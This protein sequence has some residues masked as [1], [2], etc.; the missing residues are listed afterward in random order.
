MMID[1]H[2]DL[3]VSIQLRMIELER[4]V[5]ELRRERDLRGPPPYGRPMPVSTHP[6][7]SQGQPLPGATS[8]ASYV[9][10][11]GLNGEPEVTRTKFHEATEPP[12]LYRSATLSPAYLKPDEG[13]WDQSYLSK[14]LQ[15]MKDSEILEL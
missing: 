13:I 14:A 5:R 15:Q 10:V 4:E 9:Q 1:N 7:V 12:G 2:Q 6:Y 3:E 11:R 8:K